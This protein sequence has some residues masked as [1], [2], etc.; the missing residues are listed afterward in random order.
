MFPTLDPLRILIGRGGI[1]GFGRGV[2]GRPS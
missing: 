2:R 1:D